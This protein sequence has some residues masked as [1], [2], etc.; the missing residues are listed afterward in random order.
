MDKVAIVAHFDPNSS[1]EAN[2]LDLLACL[3]EAFDHTVLV[4]TSKIESNLVKGL[5]NLTVITRPNFGYDFYSYRVGLTFAL[6]NWQVRGALL[7]NSSFAILSRDTFRGTLRRMSELIG[8]YDVVGATESLQFSWHIQ[9]YLMLLGSN[10]LEAGWFQA[11]LASIEP[12]N[13][14]FDTIV[15]FE[16]GLSVGIKQNNNKVTTL[17]RPKLVE[18]GRAN[19]YWDHDRKGVHAAA[20]SVVSNTNSSAQKFNPVHHLAEFVAR[21][22]GYV[23]FE[24]LRDNPHE[25][26]LSFVDELCEPG[27]LGAIQE[28]VSRNRLRYA[29]GADSLSAL[30]PDSGPV[31]SFK[32]ARWRQPN[33]GEVTVAVVLHLYYAEMIPEICLLLKNIVL[34]FDLHVTTPFEG[35]VTEIFSNF[36]ELAQS[37]SVYCSE[38]RG[39][40]IGPFVSIYRSGVLDR[41]DVVLKLHSKKSTYSA[42]GSFWRDRLYQSVAGDSLTAL[43]SIDLVRSGR[44]GIVGPHRYYL[45]NDRFWGANRE[46]MRRLLNEMTALDFEQ[47]LELGFFAGSMFW[48]AP[49]AL[50]PLKDIPE[51]SLSFEQ[52]DGQ[53]DGTLAHAI[54]RVFCLIARSQGFTSSSVILGGRDIRGYSSVDNEV[55]VL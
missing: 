51:T 21:Q 28:M 35:G 26:D 16:L 4:T 48:F 44:T 15:R 30:K 43:R 49:R 46:T 17:I 5:P 23:K 34:P 9:S 19:D 31:P 14:K 27:R 42:N 22:L 12:T 40:D 29:R 11:F 38:N 45:T 33:V 50:E 13:S 41:Y 47:D 10:V 1:V 20:R 32:L 55:P 37:V 2:F 39:R 54:E 6:E 25:I 24:V 53:Q 3:S 8:S 7:V 18:I 52:E 36:S